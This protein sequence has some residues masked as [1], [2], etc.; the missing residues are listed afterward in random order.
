VEG[1]SSDVLLLFFSSSSSF[2]VCVVASF[3]NRFKKTP[4]LGGAGEAV[5]GQ[6]ARKYET[7]RNGD[8]DTTIT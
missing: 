4:P 7:E 2:C 1:S 3:S 8:G 6:L 5:S